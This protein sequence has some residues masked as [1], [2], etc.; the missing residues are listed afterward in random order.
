M[1]Y[2]KS[3][4]TPFWDEVEAKYDLRV[5]SASTSLTTRQTWRSSDM[6]KRNSRPEEGKRMSTNHAA[7]DIARMTIAPR[8]R[9]SNTPRLH[10]L[11]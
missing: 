1:L 2:A 6:P 9:S 7:Q 8:T 3:E 5:A 4:D 11:D 10:S